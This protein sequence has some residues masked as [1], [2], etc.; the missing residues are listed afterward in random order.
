MLVA[1]AVG[2]F[3]TFGGGCSRVLFIR[4]ETSSLLSTTPNSPAEVRNQQRYNVAKS[5]A[6]F[7]SLSGRSFRH[8]TRTQACDSKSIARF[9]APKMTRHVIVRT[10]PRRVGQ[11]VESAA[12]SFWFAIADDYRI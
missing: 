3:Q 6:G 12:A 5:V 4:K 2:N 9:D 1:R 10:G 8:L 11:S 7:A